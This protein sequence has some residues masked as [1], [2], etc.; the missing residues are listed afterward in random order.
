[1]KLLYWLDEWLTLSD[2]ERQAKLP[3]SGGDLLGDVYVK[4]HFVD[5]N[6]P[7]LFTFSPAGTDIQERDLNEDFA[8]WGYHLAQKQDVNIIAFQHLGKSNWFRN[9]NLIFFIE[10]LSTLLSPFKTKLGYGLSR[11]GF[12]VG[13]FAKLLKL[14]KV[15]LFHPVSTKNK[16][17][18]PWDD[19]SSTEIAQQYDW[20]DD[21]HDLDL[22]DAKGY[23]IYDPTNRIDRQH[24]KRYKQLTHLRVFGMG[25]GTHAT[26]LNK[27]GFYKQVAVDFIRDQQIDIAQFRLQTK[28]LRLKEDYYKKLNKANAKSAHRQ[29]LLSTAHT[30]LIDEKAAHVKEHQEKIDIQPLIE[31]AIKHQDESPNDAIKLLEV[32]QQLVPDDPLVEHKLRQLE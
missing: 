32:A 23:I 7:L 27:F 9:R 12:A 15:L 31:V 10:Q 30:I 14:D 16:L 5:L 11:G 8:P 25:H 6:K 29:A 20:Q 4:Y 21:Y 13:A 22:G 17:I 18:A 19:R 2:D 3:A 28:T 24:A 26:Y 1:M